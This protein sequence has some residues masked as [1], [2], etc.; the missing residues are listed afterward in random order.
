MNTV[1]PP[2]LANSNALVG[3]PLPNNIDHEIVETIEMNDVVIREL[4]FEPR[5]Y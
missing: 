3:D 2:P 5:M 4:D 1:T